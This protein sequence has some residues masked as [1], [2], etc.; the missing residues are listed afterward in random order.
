M[1]LRGALR[2]VLVLLLWI[3]VLLVVSVWVLLVWLVALLLL[4]GSPVHC[5]PRLGRGLRVCACRLA[6]T[7][8]WM[9]RTVVMVQQLLALVQLLQLRLRDAGR[10]TA[11]SRRRRPTRTALASR[12]SLLLGSPSCRPPAARVHNFPVLCQRH[13]V[14][15]W[16]HQGMRPCLWC[17]RCGGFRCCTRPCCLAGSKVWHSCQDSRP[18]H[19]AVDAQ[20]LQILL[21]ELGHHLLVHL[22]VTEAHQPHAQAVTV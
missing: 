3:L 16:Q 17:R 22:P 9:S 12:V 10:C 21:R 6:R 1:L 13:R 2:K 15:F 11:A 18:C 8:M 20:A 7:S 5:A 14:P 19:G 4:V